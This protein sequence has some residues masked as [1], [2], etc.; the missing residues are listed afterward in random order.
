MESIKYGTHSFNP[1]TAANRTK[2]QFIA[3]RVDDFMPGMTVE[4]KTRILGD[5]WDKCRAAVPPEVPAET[6]AQPDSNITTDTEGASGSNGIT[7]SPKKS[8][9]NPASAPTEVPAESAT[10]SNS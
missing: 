3:E 1:L 4:N 9:S 7:G 5:V 10:G 8:K 6:S 2:E